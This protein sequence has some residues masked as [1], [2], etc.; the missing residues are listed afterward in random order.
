MAVGEREEIVPWITR[1]RAHAQVAF[2]LD[3]QLADALEDLAVTS[4]IPHP[5]DLL[6]A[7]NQQL[8]APHRGLVDADDVFELAGHRGREWISRQVIDV[9]CADCRDRELKLW[10]HGSVQKGPIRPAAS[11]RP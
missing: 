8:V 7:P 10:L 4:K 3:L 9:L 2:L 1:E 6:H 5:G 11:R